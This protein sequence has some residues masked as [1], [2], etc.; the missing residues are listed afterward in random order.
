MAHFGI[1]HMIVSAIIHGLIYSVIWKIKRT[2]TIPEALVLAGFVLAVI[3]IGAA[4][5]GRFSNTN[6]RY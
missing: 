6:N 1:G 2:L 4:L 5:A 3:A